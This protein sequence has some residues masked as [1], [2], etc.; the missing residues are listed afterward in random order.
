MSALTLNYKNKY[1]SVKKDKKL[2]NIF[3]L[4][5]KCKIKRNRKSAIRK[6]VTS[7]FNIG[8]YIQE[9]NIQ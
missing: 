8:I 6:K 5:R 4:N 7:E 2:I 9:G 1:C 3:E